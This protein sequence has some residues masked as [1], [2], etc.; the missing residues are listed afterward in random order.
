LVWEWYHI[1]GA[2]I[3]GIVHECIEAQ[4]VGGGECGADNFDGLFK[5]GWVIF[6]PP[7]LYEPLIYLLCSVQNRMIGDVIP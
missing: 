6:A 4:G 3:Q 5:I 2:V 1:Q 7:S